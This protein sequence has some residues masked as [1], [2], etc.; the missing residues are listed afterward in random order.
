MKTRLFLAAVAIGILVVPSG[1]GDAQD[2]PYQAFE[3]YLE[4]LAQQIGMPGLSALIVHDNRIAWHKG[5]GYADV[6]NRVAADFRTPYPIGGVTQAITGV[7]V[8][9]CVDRHLLQ[10]DDAIRT[11]VPTFP[12]NVRVRQVLA[13]AST[14]RYVY[15]PA[16]FTALTPVVEK[17]LSRPF[18]VATEVEIL[19]RLV[20]RRSV[21]GL[22]LA[23]PGG[24][25]ARALF[26]S[27]T[28]ERHAR[29][30][31]EMAVPYRIRNRRHS[32]SEYPT[33]G[34][35]AAA[36]LVSTAED[37]AE[38]E[39]RLDDN[40][41]IP[42]D[43]NTL[44]TMWSQQRF[45][46]GGDQILTTPTGL[47]WFVQTASGVPLVW[48]FGH[49]PDAAS[50]LIVKMPSKKLTMILLSNSPG[51]A[52]GYNFESGDVTASPFVKV[53]LRLFI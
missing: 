17:C 43:A 35:D 11:F 46:V 40:D 21:P 23:L 16:A 45:D 25:D 52:A 47:G 18:R 27:T 49:I 1:R 26:D 36:G 7:L 24:A 4:P 8:G 19:D 39:R 44:R 13:H 30:L 3:R 20:M 31:R 48:T 29:V 22:D 15:D 38:F 14:N 28:S 51:L 6:E 9:M 12:T 5:V 42:I 32:R 53:F 10:V 41:N 34:L 2:F 33:Y 37:L 50:A